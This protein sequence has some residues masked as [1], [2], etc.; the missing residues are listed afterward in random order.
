L[1]Q[2]AAEVGKMITVVVVEQVDYALL[3][4]QQAVEAH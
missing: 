1:L 2:V 4:Q 3:L